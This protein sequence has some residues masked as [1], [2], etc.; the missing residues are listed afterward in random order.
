MHFWKRWFLSSTVVALLTLVVM[1]AEVA[2]R[3]KLA[4]RR[5]PQCC[6]VE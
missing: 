1:T 5:Q 3:S 4:D 2:L 6:F